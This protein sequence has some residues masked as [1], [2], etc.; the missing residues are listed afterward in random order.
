MNN[1]RQ[2]RQLWR[3]A[4]NITPHLAPPLDFRGN[5][6]PSAYLRFGVIAVCAI[7]ALAIHAAH[8]LPFIADDALISLRY[9][10]RLIE[11]RGLTWTNGERVEGYSNLLWVLITAALGALGLDLIDAA[12]AAGF[13]GMAAAIA[14]VVW[15]FVRGGASG[16]ASSATPAA[17]FAAFALA[18]SGPIAVW[19][20]GGLEQG[21][22]IGLL[23][24]AIVTLAPHLYA[25]ERTTLRRLILPGILF[26]C[27]TW[28]RP[29]APM[30]AVI[31]AGAL[32][33]AG[34]RRLTSLKHAAFLFAI[35]L[36][37]VAAQLAFRL[38]YYDDWLPNTAY[39]KISFS[40]KHAQDGWK[41]L[42][43][44]AKLFMPLAIPATLGL[45]VWFA[46]AQRFDP[47][48]LMLG[49]MM[50]AWSV[51]V[52]IIGGDI[53]PARR[54]F[55]PLILL[56]AFAGGYAMLHLA[57]RRRIWFLSM[58]WIALVGLF[59]I[60]QDRQLAD[61]ENHRALTEIINI[62][63]GIPVG[64]LLRTAFADTQP[65]LAIDPAGFVP[66]F[67]KLPALDMFGL[68]DRYLAH[69]RP[70][71]FGKGWIGH[72]LGNGEYILSRQPDLM[73]FHGNRGSAHGWS[74]SGK[75]LVAMPEF[76]K[77]Y[78]LIHTIAE[79]PH[80]VPSLIWMRLDSSRIGIR[81]TAQ[82][83]EIPAYW[84][85]NS[86]DTEAGLHN[87]KLALRLP[88]NR[89]ATLDNVSLPPGDYLIEGAPKLR[90][91]IQSGGQTVAGELPLPVT[92]GANESATITLSAAAD[93][94]V[95]QITLRH[96]GG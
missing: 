48:L 15:Y 69:N 24:A 2:R 43:D 18:L 85:A 90:V 70:A 33:I 12:R 37:F 61:K 10:E 30:F 46:R 56:S 22:L 35:P 38:W 3:N 16:D 17:A 91:K 14:L 4:R 31:A 80:R 44:G 49:A 29:D 86:R 72:E 36:G 26:G 27:L 8:Y 50:A 81:R 63:T 87:G 28:T 45:A 78:R 96:R 34:G 74:P 7:A 53:F 83:I 40:D 58:L 82:R 93:T 76:H 95:T 6:A 79:D 5:P 20:I 73:I 89:E 66:Y 19:A 55:T 57:R 25:P 54:H 23:A 71:N 59:Y 75:Q 1:N 88:A 60:H 13:A 94:F 11:G 62:K 39:A 51:Y 92:I 21:L 32:F 67:S 9:A 77:Q 42:R 41:Y 68:N 64:K 52:M 65:L 84:F 47:M